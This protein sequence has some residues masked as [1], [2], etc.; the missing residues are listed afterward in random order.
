MRIEKI[1]N[2]NVILS[3]EDGAEIIV[4]GKGIGFKKKPG[5]E[6]A[7]SVVEKKFRLDSDSRVDR[8][9]ELIKNIPQAHLQISVEIIEYA[10][11]VMPNSFSDSIYIS[12][13]DHIN[14]SIE[15]VKN[16]I[17][18]D[19]PLLE[20][21]RSFYQSEYL[22]GEYAVALIER[23]LNVKL[24]VDEAASIAMHFVNAQC[25][26]D[27]NTTMH[28]TSLIK[29]VLE[30]VEQ[31]LGIKLNDMGLYY[32]RFV[33]H[34]KFLSQRLFAGQLMDNQDDEFVNM[35]SGL[36]E[37]EFRIAN[38][39]GDL[40]RNKY[41]KQITREEMVYL[42]VHIKRIQPENTSIHVLK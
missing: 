15:R 29:E 16:G 1:I 13:T 31:R 9:S 7:D 3:I 23:K 30:L 22:V 40:I 38:E 41:N 14:F 28:V 12:L 19:N 10:K 35:I 20:E 8:F 34:L 4:M 21:V 2:N 32:T 42:T 25:T 27:M 37:K 5:D 26:G 39:I 11:S 17:I 24:P 18:F 36:Y 33:T 6:V